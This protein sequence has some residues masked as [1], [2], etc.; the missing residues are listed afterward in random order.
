MHAPAGSELKEWLELAEAAALLGVHYTTLRRWADEGAL[1][2]A[3]TPGGRRRFQR[4]ALLQFVDRMRQSGS[5]AAFAGVETAALAATRRDLVTLHSQA[6]SWIQALSPEQRACLRTTGSTLMA[7]LMQ[8]ISRIEPAES[9]LEEG[10]TIT[11]QYAEICYQAGLSMDQTM[12]AFQFFQRSILDTTHEAG[13][14]R[15][16]A[17]AESLRLYRRSTTFFDE[18]IVELIARYN[19]IENAHL[20]VSKG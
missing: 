9:L 1:E 18:L 11:G 10:R 12:R 17:D 15:G 16:V 7:L 4:T 20:I 2:C 13:A 14:W 19:E 3:R 6:H 8:Y 5:P